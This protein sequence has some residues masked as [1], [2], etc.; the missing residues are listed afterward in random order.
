MDYRISVG[1][2]EEKVTIDAVGDGYRVTLAGRTVTVDVRRL[3]PGTVLS[4][5][6]DGESH[7]AEVEPTE[8]GYDVHLSTHSLEVGLVPELLARAGQQR[9]KSV[10]SGPV[11]VTSQ[12]PGVVVSVEVAPGD[13]VEI[14]S[15]VVIVEAMKMQNEFTAPA[16][17]VI[18][19]VMV[20]A[21]DAVAAGQVLLTIDAG[22]PEGAEA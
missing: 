9:K 6:I 7:E 5:L 11:V 3:D 16:A 19:E 20:A 12:M 15:A 18:R 8:T 2:R 22:T 13:R 17:G 10:A 1:E 21:G 14:G 4:M